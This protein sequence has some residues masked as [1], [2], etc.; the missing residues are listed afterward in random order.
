MASQFT[1]ATARWLAHSANSIP[2]GASTQPSSP[3]ARARSSSS[4]ANSA[5]NKT[6]APRY[7]GSGARAAAAKM[8][9]P[10]D[11]RIPAARSSRASPRSIR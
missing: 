5:V 11:E 10:A 1:S 6:M 4:P 2:S 3:P 7:N 8:R 9:A